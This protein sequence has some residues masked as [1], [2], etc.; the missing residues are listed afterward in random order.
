MATIETR[1]AQLR[2]LAVE[3]LKKR[4]EFWA[5]LATYVVI[6][7]MIVVVWFAVGGGFFWPVFPLAGWGIGLFFHGLDTFRRPYSE[8]RIRREMDRLR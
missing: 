4:S 3:R 8:D 5:R 6:N 7:A 1:D 2:A